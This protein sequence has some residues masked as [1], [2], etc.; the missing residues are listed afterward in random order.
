MSAARWLLLGCTGCVPALVDPTPLVDGP[1]VLAVVAEPPEVEPGGTVRMGALVADVDGEVAEPT[2]E[3]ALCGVPRP[4]AELGPIDPDCAVADSDALRPA[5]TGPTADLEIPLDACS[6]FG[7]N[8]PPAAAGEEAGRPADPD[9]TGGY[10]QPVLA[11][12]VDPAAPLAFGGVRL[13]CGLPSVT[14]ELAIA[15]NRDYRNNT[16]PAVQQWSLGGEPLPGTGA[17]DRARSV[18][19]GETL[20]IAVDWPECPSV[21]ECGDAV[22][23]S[24]EDTV[25]CP[26]DCVDG[27]GCAGAETY[28]FF[29]PAQGVLV[30][31]QETISVAFFGTGGAFAASRVG[32]AGGADTAVQTA[33]TAPAAA[34]PVWLAAVIR[35][36]RGGVGFVAAWVDVGPTTEAP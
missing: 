12:P 25:S 31:K 18:A 20:R 21:A 14:Q 16:R 22:C 23:S 11:F 4:L 15:W 2:I 9:P 24:G 29:D 35:D 32:V 26:E 8:P 6:L 7:P 19:P 30:E 33:W 13:R 28:V 5:G 36:D 3:W 1:R 10:T 27:V 17:P 34:G